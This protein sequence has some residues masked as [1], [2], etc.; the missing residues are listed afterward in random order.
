MKYLLSSFVFFMILSTVSAQLG[1]DIIE[2][3]NKRCVEQVP[4]YVD[5]YPDSLFY[6]NRILF[7]RQTP[8]SIKPGY[9]GVFLADNN[10][11]GFFASGGFDYGL[12]GY[13]LTWIVRND[14]LFI[15]R[16]S[17]F[18]KDF[19][20]SGLS[21]DALHSRMEKF[22]E[23]RFING[24]LFV[25]WISGDLR[26]ITKYCGFGGFD[27]YIYALGNERTYTIYNDD[28]KYGSIL[29][30]KNGLVVDFKEDRTNNPH[31][32]S[33]IDQREWDYELAKRRLT[34]YVDAEPDTVMYGGIK[35]L[36]RQTPLSLKR[37]YTDVYHE[38]EVSIFNITGN[39]SILGMKGYHLTWVTR[40]D[41][42]FIREVF[43]A[44]YDPGRPTLSKD[45]IILRME[46]FTG[47]RFINGLLFVDWIT[48]EF[49]VMTKHIRNFREIIDVE[50]TNEK[51]EREY[52]DDRKYGSYIEIKNGIIIGFCEEDVREIKN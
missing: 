3:H 43:P 20:P 27:W 17:F 44:Y 26:V 1:M 29:T 28:R 49:G 13:R 24:L 9:S 6:G 25:D 14:S 37:G 38:D 22:T 2:K 19:Y 40:N 8:L 45:T 23:G 15:H 48:G 36:F 18:N 10:E 34:Y 33:N 35:Y 4:N 31:R 41:S 39:G 51:R 11:V 30:V 21:E 52:K 50:K 47:R 12:R 5:S 46:E 16:I 7:F 32:Q 42:L